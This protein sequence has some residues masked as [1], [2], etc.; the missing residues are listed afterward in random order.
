MTREKVLEKYQNGYTD[1]ESEEFYEILSDIFLESANP[2]ELVDKAYKVDGIEFNNFG[3]LKDEVYDLPVEGYKNLY[4]YIC[5]LDYVKIVNVLDSYKKRQEYIDIT[6]N[7]LGFE[8]LEQPVNAEL[9]YRIY[10][11]TGKTVL[12]EFQEQ[13]SKLIN[14]NYNTLYVDSLKIAKDLYARGLIGALKFCSED[15]L[16]KIIDDESKKTIIDVMIENN[17]LF[18]LKIEGVAWKNSY[19]NCGYKCNILDKIIPSL[20]KTVL[21]YLFEKDSIKRF[22]YIDSKDNTDY[23]KNILKIAWK[24][25][26]VDLLNDMPCEYLKWKIDEDDP[27]SIDYYTLLKNKGIKYKLYFNTIINDTR[28]AYDYLM[29]NS[30]D[31]D[32][33][34]RR[35]DFETFKSK[36]NKDSNE[37]IATLFFSIIS[38]KDLETQSSCLKKLYNMGWLDEEVISAALY[39]GLRIIQNNR[40]FYDIY[41]GINANHALDYAMHDDGMKEKYENN[42]DYL[43]AEFI[44]TFEKDSDEN[45][46][47]AILISYFAYKETNPI[48]AQKELKL[49]IDLKKRDSLFD[50]NSNIN[51]SYVHEIMSHKNLNILNCFDLDVLNH[52]LAHILFSNLSKDDIKDLSTLLP[53]IQDSKTKKSC[54]NVGYNIDTTIST[55]SNYYKKDFEK[56]IKSRFGSIENYK[57]IMREEYKAWLGDPKLL[58]DY[59]INRNQSKEII[60]ILTKA[61]FEDREKYLEEWAIEKYVEER[62]V[63]EE[64]TFIY[65]SYKRDY[66]ELLLYENFMD[67]YFGGALTTL[68]KTE[69]NGRLHYPVSVHGEEY[70][71]N[72]EIRIDEMFADFVAL[73][74]LAARGGEES[75]SIDYLNKIKSICGEEVYNELESLYEKALDKI[76]LDEEIDDD[77]SIRNQRNM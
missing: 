63:S 11:K 77:T 7:R 2:K 53:N 32:A 3:K 42:I 44:E 58:A 18:G 68:Y 66:R 39:K 51:S 46:I 49:L 55:F 4:D 17:L 22:R 26:R 25:E 19:G 15:I 24:M 8:G 64:R 61:T 34:L 40:D 75:K 69:L 48:E 35:C 9:L 45:T 67:A 41:V 59:M 74:K 71:T 13:I 60:E 10:S 70:F 20:N 54:E 31:L 14:N 29:D 36:Y 56:Y 27:N 62:Y 50:I 21:E 47:K 52:E 5:S 23:W 38:T 6:L 16:F 30:N 28:V 65:E 72:N 43:S 57:N 73:K 12:D 76:E 33:F 1:Y 37:T